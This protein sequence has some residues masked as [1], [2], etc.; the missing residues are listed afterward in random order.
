VATITP[1][2]ARVRKKKYVQSPL[3][4]SESLQESRL[5]SPKLQAA[6]RLRIAAEI[7][8]WALAISGLLLC[9]CQAA[10]SRYSIDLAPRTMLVCHHDTGSLVVD[11]TGEDIV[12]QSVTGYAV[13]NSMIVGTSRT[14]WFVF[15][16]KNIDQ[17]R[18]AHLFI[19]EAPWNV[20]LK[21]LGVTAPPLRQP[22]F[23][24]ARLSSVGPMALTALAIAVALILAGFVRIRGV[25]ST[26]NSTYGFPRSPG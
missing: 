24:D 21:Q 12:V 11:M 4:T 25:I 8:I 5:S 19:T 1:R 10:L 6:I 20:Y 3:M 26:Y 15:D 16:T 9:A 2:R 22:A 17:I 18:P 23:R 7:G 14:G 13:A